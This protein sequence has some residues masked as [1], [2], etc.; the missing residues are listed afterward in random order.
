M[1]KII[2]FEQIIQYMAVIRSLVIH[3]AGCSNDNS[4]HCVGRFGAVR[5]YP[6]G[7]DAHAHPAVQ[8]LPQGDDHHL[9]FS[10][11]PRL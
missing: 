1:I 6:G 7:H 5:I 11:S 3:I 8:G 4:V 10:P 2:A 9:W